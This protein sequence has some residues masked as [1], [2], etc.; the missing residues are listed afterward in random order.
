[1]KLN[2]LLSIKSKNKS[3]VGRGISAGQGKTAG[4][5]TKGQKSRS[6]Y[7]IPRRFEGGQTPLLQRLP[8]IHGTKSHVYKPQTIS[9]HE[10]EQHFEDKTE[11]TK[12]LLWTNKLISRVDRPVKIIGATKRNKNYQ[13]AE[14]I[15]LTKKLLSEISKSTEKPA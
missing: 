1:M 4:R 2:Q 14:D 9:W 15:I 11:I 13:F 12:D 3:R 7:N 5:G 10:L 6:G 8:K